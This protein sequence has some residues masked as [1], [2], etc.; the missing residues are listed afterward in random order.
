MQPDPCY[1]WRQADGSRPSPQD[2]QCN[3]GS[4]D[5]AGSQG[6]EAGQQP[7][8]DR[9]DNSPDNCSRKDNITESQDE[10]E[11]DN[12]VLREEL[13]NLLTC[14]KLIDTSS[15]ALSSSP[16]AALWPPSCSPC[17]AQGLGS[18]L[19]FKPITL[20]SGYSLCSACYDV[21]PHELPATNQHQQCRQPLPVLTLDD[22]RHLAQPSP[23]V[24]FILQK[25]VQILRTLPPKPAGHASI[26][27]NLR[28]ELECPLCS[29]VF[30]SP[31]TI[32]CG[33]AFCRSCFLRARDHADN[34]PVCRQPFLMGPQAV[35]GIDL[36]IDRIIQQCLTSAHRPASPATLETNHTI[37]LMVCS[38]GFPEVPM[39]LQIFEPRYK[40]M[41]R[42]SL[43]TDRK[44]GIV[45]PAFDHH[46]L[47]NNQFNHPHS[48]VIRPAAHQDGQP[49]S[50]VHP[51][52]TIL[53][54]RKHETAVDGRM[55]IEARGC[56]RFRIEGLL[57]SLDGY[58]VAKIHVFD[59]MPIQE[60]WLPPQ[61]KEQTPDCD[62]SL[63]NH[64]I[65]CPSTEKL[66]DTCK[67]FIEV[68]RSGSSPWI[69][70]RL[71]DTFGPM[72]DLPTEFTYWVAMVLPISDQYKATLLPIISYRSRLKILVRW[73][74]VLK[75]QWNSQGCLIV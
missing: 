37:P 46:R 39:F 42:R 75:S 40:L 58:L 50:P 26:R 28:A 3:R 2:N 70:E 44:F 69:L 22:N 12:E 30:D 48:A 63:G 31:V 13:V 60:G 49:T 16:A 34:C 5:S 29:L 24:N 4:P 41:I 33:H 20:D 43:S 38:I 36:L 21:Y 6:A 57:G 25:V 61:A 9:H 7:Q 27:S 19:L 1:E 56:D 10:Q 73:I 11:A 59:D 17:T 67:E 15:T 71:Y 8:Q 45:I 68:L 54:I 64:L 55:L 62:V 14:L 18:H 51:F 47:S 32:S 23:T 35:P 72:P 53:E 74:E 52:G 66:M 65:T